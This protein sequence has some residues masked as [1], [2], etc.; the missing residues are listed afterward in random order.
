MKTTMDPI[1]LCKQWWR[2]DL[3]S[4]VERFPT[5]TFIAVMA[6]SWSAYGEKMDG[7]TRRCR[8]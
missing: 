7:S 6:R 8:K 1:C 3:T 2:R 5:L 4:L